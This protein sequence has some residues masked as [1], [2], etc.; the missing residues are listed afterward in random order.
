MKKRENRRRP[1]KEE[2]FEESIAWVPADVKEQHLYEILR[3]PQSLK[4]EPLE[5]R[6]QEAKKVI[7]LAR[8]E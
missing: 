4:D 1:I 6:K 8:Y 7:Y 3:N 2:S 5:M